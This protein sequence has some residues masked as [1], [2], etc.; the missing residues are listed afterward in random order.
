LVIG[1]CQ[2]DMEITNGSSLKSK[3][4]V[5]KSIKDRIRR[6]NISIA[7]IGDHDLWKRA[8]IGMACIGNEE[9][10][11]NGVLSQAVELISSN[12]N[13]VV[14]DYEISVIK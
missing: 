5:L 8:K 9:G 2:I 7:E 13:V 10:Y 6:F 4:R 3:R 12:G 11:V 14:L 1:I